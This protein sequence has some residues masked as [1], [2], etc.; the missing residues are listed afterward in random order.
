MNRPEQQEKEVDAILKKNPE[1]ISSHVWGE[2]IA[3]QCGKLARRLETGN[4]G[5]P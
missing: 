1:A 5:R 4:K 2:T 3:K